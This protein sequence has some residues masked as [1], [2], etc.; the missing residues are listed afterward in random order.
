MIKLEKITKKYIWENTQNII[1]EK[2]DFEVAQWD[3]I[4]IVWKSGSWKTSLLNIMAGLID[5]NEWE[6]TINKNKY[7]KMS[8][9]EKTKFRWKNMS[10][11]FQQFHLIP[12]L[13]VEENI[14]LTLDINKI[15]ARFTVD[16]ILQKIG[17]ENKNNNYPFELSGWEQQRVAIAR[18]FIWNTDVLLA[19]E[20]TWNLDEKNAH[21]IMNLLKNMHKETKNTIILITHDMWVAKFANKVYRL[22]NN[23][24]NLIENV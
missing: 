24:L 5:F 21:N 15:S 10:F 2:L 8:L 4:A 18:A 19:D 1:Y 6:V 3:F 17:L 13:T 20:P 16:E 9:N 23:T 7:S 12:N 22:E 11:I 14:E